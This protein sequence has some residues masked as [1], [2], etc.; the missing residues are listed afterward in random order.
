LVFISPITKT[1]SEAIK[2]T[3]PRKMN[4]KL[5]VLIDV[6]SGAP[7]LNKTIVSR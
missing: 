6:V 2:K 7:E 3:G 4:S 5:F 1:I